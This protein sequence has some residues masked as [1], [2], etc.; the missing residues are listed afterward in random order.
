MMWPEAEKKAEVA[1]IEY[2]QMIR[3]KETM[4]KMSS[5]EGVYRDHMISVIT[6]VS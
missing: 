4:K 1:G 2:E 3:E 6:T 5:I